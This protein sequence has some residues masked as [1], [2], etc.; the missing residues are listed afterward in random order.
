M[1][2]LV[3]LLIALSAAPL[4]AL[5]GTINRRATAPA[6]VFLAA[7]SCG[8][9]IWARAAG[10]G[11]FTR[12]WSPTWHLS[13]AFTLDG[14]AILYALL[15]TGI[16]VAILIFAAAYI[17][18]HLAHQGRSQADEPRFFVFVLLFMGAMVGLVMAQDLILIFLFWDLTAIASYFL[19]G[20]DQ[21]RNE[22]RTA[23]LMALL[24]TGISAVVILIG[25]LLLHWQHN[26]FLLPEIIQ[27][28]T[29]GTT[30]T[31][32]VTLIAIG[33]LAKSAQ[34]PLHFWLP[35]AM[36]AP[37]PVSAY[38]HSAAMVAAGVFLLGRFYP[39]VHLS[40]ELL[41][42]LF[43]VGLASMMIA[44]LLALVRR[45]FKPLL[46]YSTIAQYG[47]VVVMLS[48][49]T[50]AGV[51][52]ATFYVLAHALAKSA[53]FLTAGAVT[54]STDI[55]DFKQ[56]GGVGRSQPLL[57]IASGIAAAGLGAL[58]LTI[59]FF[60]DELFFAAALARGP[61]YTAVA[62]L[63]AAL[64]FSYVWHFWSSIFLG[65]AKTT[66][67]PIPL[68]FMVPI[69][70]LATLVLL[71][72]IIVGPAAN[73]A[74]AAGQVSFPALVAKTPA[75]HFDTRPENLLALATYALGI[76]I[77]I[78]RRWWY[79][80]VERFAVFGRQV[81]PERIYRAS[82]AG[83]N[84]LSR[85]IVA[86]ELRDLRGRLT[87]VLVPTALLA[88]AGFVTTPT[89]GAY[90]ISAFGWQD[91]PLA[92]ALLL[93]MV[94]AI[95]TTIPRS[96]LTIVLAL[97]S[98]GYS[99]SIAFA[100]FG[101]PNVALIMA[102]VE[103]ILTILVLGVL[104]LF[105]HDVLIREHTWQE[106]RSL[107]YRDYAIGIIAAIFAFA[108]AWSTLSQP[109]ITGT[110][111]RDFMLMAPEAHAKNV[112]TA[113]LADFRGLDTLGEITVIWIAFVG[114]LTLLRRRQ[115]QR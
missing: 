10:G 43:V 99:L 32:A 51:F 71:G 20:Y 62:V 113:I 1:T 28:A 96:H 112:V 8:A 72:G 56:I 66:T 74:I 102:L 16:G 15:A 88:A 111:A 103:T 18:L 86:A 6:A 19:I 37:T 9:V 21:H 33:A 94:G 91:L 22:A 73:L 79:A 67:K 85:V 93:T 23:A 25:F 29:P 75:Y 82:L 58:P 49:G 70:I 39:L 108:T 65:P 40:Q 5:I 30:H 47:Y 7:L 107:R 105:P 115:V 38:L 97:S 27:Q 42:G 68:A 76:G 54:E 77:V 95:T 53:L 3:P 61:F 69:C 90:R 114:M 35:R 60:K 98:V 44:S 2:V 45:N 87:T 11:T 64:T 104:S 63:G 57:A 14:L 106:P 80:A 26:T 59:G 24:I 110:V 109:A 100:F 89:E 55:D 52:G 36:A 17:P 12:P 84:R 31:V 92:L 41:N 83:I 50:A 46:A 81:G 34:I 101:A 48:F 13:F 4:A 78:T